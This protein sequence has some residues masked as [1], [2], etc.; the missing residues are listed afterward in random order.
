MQYSDI[1]DWNG[2]GGGQQLLAL[3]TWQVSYRS[4][5]AISGKLL[6]LLGRYFPDSTAGALIA[7]V[8]Q[9]VLT[10]LVLVYRILVTAAC[11]FLE[12]I[13]RDQGCR[14]LVIVLLVVPANIRLD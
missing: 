1:S 5:N 9:L 3:Q 6:A 12:H 10:R 8:V 2:D 13:K 4:W 14:M 11:A 7:H